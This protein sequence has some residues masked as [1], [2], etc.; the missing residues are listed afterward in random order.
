MWLPFQGEKLKTAQQKKGAFRSRAGHAGS[1]SG[2]ASVLV[3]CIDFAVR[4]LAD[5]NKNLRIGKAA[6]STGSKCSVS[7]PC[8]IAGG[9]RRR[10]NTKDSIVSLRFLLFDFAP[11]KSA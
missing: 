4:G 2:V 10:F 9:E 6:S 7:R 8:L 1:L 5:S 3:I 11:R